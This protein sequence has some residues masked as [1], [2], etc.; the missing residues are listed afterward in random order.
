[1]ATAATAAITNWISALHLPLAKHE[2]R[3][4]L[5][6]VLG[7]DDSRC[8]EFPLIIQQLQLAAIHHERAVERS[9]LVHL[10]ILVDNLKGG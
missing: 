6:L 7:A 9:G 10:G 2:C 3:A 4:Q 1:M 5:K 8:E